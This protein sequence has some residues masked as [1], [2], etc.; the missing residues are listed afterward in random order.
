MWDNRRDCHAQLVG[1]IV[2]KGRTPVMVDDVTGEGAL[3]TNYTTLASGRTG[4]CQLDDLS[5]RPVTLGYLNYRGRSIY[6]SRMPRRRWKHGLDSQNISAVSNKNTTVGFDAMQVKRALSSCIL[7]NHAAFGEAL[8][9]V[10]EEAIEL[11]FSRIFS[12]GPAREGENLYHKGR[13]VG[14]VQND[15]PVLQTKFRFLEESLQEGLGN[16]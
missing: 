6:L 11:S 9:R 2:M 7:G 8:D 15:Q 10:R 1:T 13:K 5:L 16:A 3:R 4:A 14:T 12:L